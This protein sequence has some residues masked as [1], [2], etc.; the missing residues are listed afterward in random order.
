MTFRNGLEGGEIALFRP[1]FAFFGLWS[2]ASAVKLSS[3]KTSDWEKL[4]FLVEREGLLTVQ[5][6][7]KSGD[8]ENCD[9]VSEIGDFP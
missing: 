4:S 5:V 9:S 1:G 2:L 8:P 3:N 7:R 6:D